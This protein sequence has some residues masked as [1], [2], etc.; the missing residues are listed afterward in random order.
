MQFKI[1]K[2]RPNTSVNGGHRQPFK[3]EVEDVEKE[4]IIKERLG[5]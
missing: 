5:H 1:G 3:I 4:V 2:E